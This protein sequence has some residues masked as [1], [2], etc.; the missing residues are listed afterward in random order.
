MLVREVNVGI[1]FYGHFGGYME[2]GERER[3]LLVF[4]LHVE[5]CGCELDSD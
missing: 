1:K 2:L 5:V 4:L 3:W